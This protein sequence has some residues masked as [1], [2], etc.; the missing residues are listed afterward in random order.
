[1]QFN[2]KQERCSLEQLDEYE[3][4]WLRKEK[5]YKKVIESQQALEDKNNLLIARREI[6]TK[7]KVIQKEKEIEELNQT[8]NKLNLQIC[9]L[10]TE[11]QQQKQS[12]EQISKKLAEVNSQLEQSKCFQQKYLE[13]NKKIS[14]ID[15]KLLAADKEARILKHNISILE[16]SKTQLKHEI[17]QMSVQNESLK[18]LLQNKETQLEEFKAKRQFEKKE[19]EK[20]FQ[21]MKTK[22]LFEKEELKNALHELEKIKDMQIFELQS[23]LFQLDKKIEAFKNLESELDKSTEKCNELEKKLEKAEISNVFKTSKIEKLNI[24]LEAKERDLQQGV[25]KNSQLIQ[26]CSKIDNRNAE[27]S[28]QLA[29]YI[30]AQEELKCL[31]EQVN[32]LKTENAQIKSKLSKLF[33][34]SE[35]ITPATYRKCERLINNKIKSQAPMCKPSDIAWIQIPVDELQTWRCYL[36]IEQV[37]EDHEEKG[38]CSKKNPACRCCASSHFRSKKNKS[39]PNDKHHCFT[40]SKNKKHWRKSSHKSGG[41]SNVISHDDCCDRLQQLK[42]LVYDRKAIQEM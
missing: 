8:I 12:I 14:D 40:K 4:Q 39:V 21:Q 10:N 22:I 29:E 30:V 7:N 28:T 31:L 18:Q 35:R 2:K 13:G 26:K 23:K 34:Q 5:E 42:N 19:C 33:D 20:S 37:P 15:S 17:S 11:K 24:E 6:C 36:N 38:F 25:A 16:N 3:K 1:M 27:L 9:K 41:I 32:T